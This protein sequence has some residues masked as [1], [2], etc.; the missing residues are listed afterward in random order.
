MLEQQF[1]QSLKPAILVP[2]T[3]LSN[4]LS[5]V[6]PPLVKKRSEQEAGRGFCLHSQSCVPVMTLLRILALNDTVCRA[7]R[8]L[9][10]AST[11]E[12]EL[13]D[14]MDYSPIS[15]SHYLELWLCLISLIFRQVYTVV[16]RS[17]YALI[18]G[19]NGRW[20]IRVFNDFF[21]LFIFQSGRIIQHA[22]LMI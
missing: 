14:H 12:P 5:S 3:F 16:V 21:E 9:S 11:L 2:I 17:L 4:Q 19:L 8:A 20:P 6:C 18:I 1:T 13:V 22:L 15:W 10:E 7:K